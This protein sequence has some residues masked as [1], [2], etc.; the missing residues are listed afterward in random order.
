MRV[1]VVVVLAAVLQ[2]CVLVSPPMVDVLGVGPRA[3]PVG[4]VSA[5]VTTGAGSSNAAVLIGGAGGDL[6][7]QV[8]P[9]VSIG[10]SMQTGTFVGGQL[11]GLLL[12][13]GAAVRAQLSVD[14][15]VAVRAGLAVPWVL[16]PT[17]GSA[18]APAVFAGPE[19]S[20]L[21]GDRFDDVDVFGVVGGSFAKAISGAGTADVL[22]AH[23]GGGL[24]WHADEH[25]ELKAGLVGYAGA[26]PSSPGNPLLGSAV[27]TGVRWIF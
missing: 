13:P 5:G 12:A 1:V 7:V 14:E 10:G 21:F 24:L 9:S 26:T 23:G 4:E 20:L 25:L 8:S 17:S 27:L 6:N 3:R 22:W 19:L 2:G 15:H 18:S 11:P 16:W